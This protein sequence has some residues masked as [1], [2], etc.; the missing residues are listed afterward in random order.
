MLG[1]GFKIME[2]L[3]HI[4]KLSKILNSGKP[5]R[6]YRYYIVVQSGVVEM[7]LVKSNKNLISEMGYFYNEDNCKMIIDKYEKGLI[8][9]LKEFKSPK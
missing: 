3:E 9:Y 7:I 4:K 2:I 5:K 8:D 1:L 6:D